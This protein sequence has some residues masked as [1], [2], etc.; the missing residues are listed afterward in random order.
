MEQILNRWI[1]TEFQD[2]DTIIFFQFGTLLE[3]KITI[4]VIIFHLFNYTK[5][6][7][8]ILMHLNVFEFLLHFVQLGKRNKY[9]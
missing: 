1:L 5:G 8:E 7:F 2:F 4:K 3:F 9:V 6:D